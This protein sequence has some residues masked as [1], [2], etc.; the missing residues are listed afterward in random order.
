[1][2]RIKEDG[3]VFEGEMILKTDE[4]GALFEPGKES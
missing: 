2:Y 1:L 4:K 3:S